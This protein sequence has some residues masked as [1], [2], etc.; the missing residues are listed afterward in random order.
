MNDIA[1]KDL[2]CIA[3]TFQAQKY[4]VDVGGRGQPCE[5]CKYAC[6]CY[7]LNKDGS[8]KTYRHGLSE[9]MRKLQT[10]TGVYLG[11]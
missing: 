1:E 11:Y 10:A 7:K 9:A 3:M 5:L 4:K 6:E 8:I 2:Y